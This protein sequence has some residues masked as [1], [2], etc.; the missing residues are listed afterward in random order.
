MGSDSE[1]FAG[2]T[3]NV[4]LIYKDTLIC[5]NAGDSRC[6]LSSNGKAVEMSKDHKPDVNN[7]ILNKL[8]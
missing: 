5:A 2:C 6:I 8:G 1:S 7:F 4:A 3:A